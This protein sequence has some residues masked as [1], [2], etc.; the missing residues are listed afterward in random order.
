MTRI[1]DFNLYF[2]RNCTYIIFIVFPLLLQACILM[3]FLFGFIL[4][5][6]CS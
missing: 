2:K 5:Y 4:K 1:N 3:V 6:H